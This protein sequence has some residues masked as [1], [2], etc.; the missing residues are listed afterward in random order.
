MFT[1]QIYSIFK[2]DILEI[3]PTF[4]VALRLVLF[5]ILLFMSCLSHYYKRMQLLERFWILDEYIASS[6]ENIQVI[7]REVF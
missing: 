7:I 2:T 1:L 3:V 6:C 4:H 5:F